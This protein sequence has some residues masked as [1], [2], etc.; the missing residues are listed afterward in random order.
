[1]NFAQIFK[2]Y[3]VSTDILNKTSFNTRRHHQ[4][5]IE[6]CPDKKFLCLQ[7]LMCNAI[8]CRFSFKDQK[9]GQQLKNIIQRFMVIYFSSIYFLLCPVSNYIRFLWLRFLWFI[10]ISNMIQ[11]I[12]PIIRN[13]KRL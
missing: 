4:Y 6:L 2:L 3:K 9:F 8:L 10:N 1:M 11:V 12:R 7:N 5:V 13:L